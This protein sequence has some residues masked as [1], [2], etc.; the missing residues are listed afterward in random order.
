MTDEKKLPFPKIYTALEYAVMR[1]VHAGIDDARE[2]L[3]ELQKTGY[4]YSI[5][6]I[7][8]AC[9]ML[10]IRGTMTIEP[11]PQHRKDWEDGK[12]R[13]RKKY[14]L[15]KTNGQKEKK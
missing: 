12:E 9:C 15:L 7:V 1:C 4:G 5:T 11:P 3:T 8:E 2:L 10:E 6:Q 13:I 14:E